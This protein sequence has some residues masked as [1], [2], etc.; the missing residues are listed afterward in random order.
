MPVDLTV[1]GTGGLHGVAG[2]FDT[3]SMDY[4]PSSP[5]SPPPS[6]PSASS[7]AAAAAAA[8][9]VSS[10]GS[11]GIGRPSAVASGDRG[12][13]SVTSFANEH[14]PTRKDSIAARDRTVS[15]SGNDQFLS[16][17][18]IFDAPVGSPGQSKRK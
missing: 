8:G 10:L 16:V 2:S 17:T 13:S 1:R 9:F 3:G 15:A 12:V 18:K 11:G 14:F 4:G 7:A 6:P 5:P